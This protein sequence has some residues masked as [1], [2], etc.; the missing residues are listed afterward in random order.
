MVL[1]ISSLAIIWLA[2]GY[3]LLLIRRRRESMPQASAKL[4]AAILN[5][6]AS[7]SVGIVSIQVF[8]YN[9]AISMAFSVCC[10]WVLGYL[11]GIRYGLLFSAQAALLGSIG[12]LASVTL[13]LLFFSSGKVVFAVDVVYI[14]LLVLLQ[15]AMDWQAAKPPR[16]KLPTTEGNQPRK[17]PVW[18]TGLLGAVVVV[19]AALI[20]VNQDRISVGQLGLKKSQQAAYDED[21][22]LQVAQITV[23]TTGFNPQNTEFA[24]GSMIKAVLHVE[25]GAGNNLRL[26]SQDLNIDAPLKQGDNLF[27]FNKP[28]PGVYNFALSDGRFKGTFTVK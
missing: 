14:I 20:L 17:L 4:I 18:T 7:A 23:N 2:A 10:A 1:S 19:M 16:K 26:I 3:L 15:K 28:L 12:T 5:I 9:L 25:S 8:E 13:G 24:T 11:S 6:L 21:N 27:V 22:N